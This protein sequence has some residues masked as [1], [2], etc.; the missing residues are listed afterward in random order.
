[1]TK[2]EGAWGW[3]QEAGA[4][5]VTLLLVGDT[6]VQ[7]RA[8]PPEVFRH[9]MPTLRDADI[10][11][12]QLEGPLSPPPADPN[13]ASIDHKERWRHSDPR[14]VEAFQ[15]A[16]FAAVA[17]ASNVCYPPQA[18]LDSIATLDAAGIKHCGAGP[19]LAAARAPAIVDAKDTRFGFL[20]YTSVFWP[21]GHAATT[22]APGCATVKA[23]TAYQPD[24]RALEMPGADPIIVTFPDAEELAAMQRDVAKLQEETDIVIVSCH[25]GVSSS[26][27]PVAYQQ[28][29]G[30]AAIDAGADIVFGHH[31]HVIQGAEIHAGKPIF[32]SLG[33][34]AFDWER[35]TGRHLDGLMLRIVVR[36]KQVRD[37]AALPVMRDSEN[38]VAVQDP[39]GAPGSAIVD[40]FVERSQTFGTDIIHRGSDVTLCAAGTRA[41][42]AD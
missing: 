22:T 12:G 6:N 11:F 5:D 42:A 33:N 25:W 4:E 26:T 38:L 23:Y 10:L 21:T 8:D 7:N 15:A 27:K 13:A 32:Y 2:F 37:I 19:D 9:V 17:C 29:I 18:A 28:A 35:M 36:D 16:G 41:A 24:R 39:A 34:F 1:M 30:R 20:S 31:P 3:S 14:M 40:A